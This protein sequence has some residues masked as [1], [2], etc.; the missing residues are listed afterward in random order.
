[1]EDHGGGTWW[2]QS[3]GRAIAL[4]VDFGGSYGQQLRYQLFNPWIKRLSLELLWCVGIGD[5][6]F[7]RRG[8]LEK[9]ME[10]LCEVYAFF[11]QAVAEASN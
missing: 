1:M 4:E 3:A 5:W 10:A 11:E 2:Y 8:N 7:I 9:S 6:N